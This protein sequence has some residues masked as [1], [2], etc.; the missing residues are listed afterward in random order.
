[1]LERWGAIILAGAVSCGA[2]VGSVGAVLGR[3]NESHALHVRDVPAG[4]A[5]AAAGLRPGD[6]ILMIEGFYVKDLTLK[7]IKAL[8]RGEIGTTVDLTV[9]RSG[10][11]RHVKVKRSAIVQHEEVKPK[12][13]TIRE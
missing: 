2:D 5:A 9:V 11:V 7:E 6:E 3:D 4:M 12:E 1:M 8:L 13:E 10:E